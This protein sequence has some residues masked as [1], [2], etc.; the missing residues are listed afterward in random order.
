MSNLDGKRLLLGVSG[1]VAAY[2]SAILVRLLR[3]AGAEV[4]VVLTEGGSRFIGEATLQ[5]LSGRP[6]R[7]DLWDAAAEAAM[8]HIELARWADLVLIAPA[9]ANLL[10][11]LAQGRADDLLTTLCLATRA[12]VVVAPAMN[13]AMWEHPATRR[14]R[15]LLEADGVTFWGPSTG[16]QACGEEGVG[17]MEA[18]EQIL[19]RLER[20][21]APGPLAGLRLLVTAGPTREAVDPVRFIGNRSSGRMGYAVARAARELGA[22]V[23]L[24]SGPVSLPTPEGVER[25]MVESARQMEGE[26]LARIEQCDIFVATA[27]VADYRPREIAPQKIKKGEERMELALVRNPD[28]LAEV[29]SLPDPPFTVGFAAESEALEDHARQKLRNKRLD[30]IAANLVGPGRGFEEEENSLKIL[31]NGG[32]VD[33]PRVRKELLARRLLEIVAER[34]HEKQK[35]KAQGA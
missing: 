34:Y 32:G 1:S 17:R 33:L 20:H 14:N 16:P 27:A 26:V 22:K 2:K 30:M 7:S 15:A 9:S 13:R 18:P 28:I 12:P 3:Q 25:V 10:S 23:T 5:A 29:A 31:W 35:H 4:Q 24:V 8:G 11:A 19:E 6:V 21:F